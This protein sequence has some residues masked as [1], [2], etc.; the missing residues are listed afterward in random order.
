[1][2][3]PLFSD[4]EPGDIVALTV[5]DAQGNSIALRKVDDAWVLPEGGDYPVKAGKV[6][7][8]LEKVIGL[9]T[10]RLVARSSA[11]H[12]QLKVA[13]DNYERRIDLETADGAAYTLY[14]GSS[15]T[16]GAT[17][18]RLEGQDETYLT[19]DVFAWQASTQ[20]AQWIDT[21]Y[22]RLEPDELLRVR[23]ENANGALT[24]VRDE[25]GEWTMEGL[26]EEDE[27]LA[28]TRVTAAI[29]QAARINLLRPLGREELPEYG[30]DA[31]QAVVTMETADE[32]YTL[33][34]GAYDEG[35]NSY[36]A[37]FSG[38]PYYVRISAMSVNSLVNNGR[39]DFLEQ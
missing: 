5:T 35:S 15:P 39:Q 24:F 30:L 22:V 2:G 25:N 33:R 10:R 36:V 4:L 13:P 16:S 31:P 11:S 26:D 38:S 32:T 27:V 8:F 1:M 34:I 21:A 28:S 17:H 7:E 9:T 19:G 12:R 20:P 29:W 3:G 18:F 14:L 23:I 6:E 37:S